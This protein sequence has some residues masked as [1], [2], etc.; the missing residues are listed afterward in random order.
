METIKLILEALY[1]GNL[2]P[3]YT[4]REELNNEAIRI[5]EC[6]ELSKDDIIELKMIL[7]IGNL[8]YNNSDRDLLPIEDG[9]YDML[10]EKYRKYNNDIYPVGATPIEFNNDNKLLEEKEM[11]KAF[12]FY[13][14]DEIEYIN[15]TMI[16]PELITRDKVLMPSDFMRPA[17]SKETGYISKRMH[18]VAHNNPELVGTFDKCKYVLTQQARDKG[19]ENDS[20][21]R[22]LER[23]FFGPLLEAGII[24]MRD[25]FTIIAELKYDGV[26]IEAEVT[27]RVLEARSRGD[28]EADIASDMTPILEGYLFPQMYGNELSKPIGMKFE[29]IVNYLNLPKLNELRGYNYINGRTAIIGIMGSSDAYKYR[30]L[31]TL[32][33]I[34]TNLKD[35]NGEPLD[36]LEELEFLNTYYTR[37]QLMRYSVFTGT[38]TQVLFLMKRFVEE[39]EYARSYLPFMYDG[40][41]FE[42][43]DKD[44]RK[45]LGRDNSID[46]YKVAVKFNPMCKQTIFRQYKYTIGQDGSITPMI[47]YDPVEFYGAIHY[48]S[49]G[50][51]YERFKKLDL[52][53]GDIIDVEY[54]NDVMPYVTK[55]SNEHNEINAKMPHNEL[56]TFPTECPCCGKPLVISPSGKSVRCTNLNCGNRAV[57]RMASTFEKLGITD[58]SEK[59]IKTVGL[60]RLVDYFEANKSVFEILGPN[61]AEALYNQLQKIKM[62]PIYDYDFFGSLG[63]TS[64]AK[65]TWKLVFSHMTVKSLVAGMEIQNQD[66][67]LA[68][69]SNI[70]GVG[71]TTANTIVNEFDFFMDDI[72]YALQNIPIQDSMGTSS[73]KQI[74]FT[75]CRDKQLVEQLVSMGCD[76]DGDAGITKSTDILI[77]PSPGYSSGRKVQ[78]AKDYGILIVPIDEFRNNMSQYL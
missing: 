9:I 55:P 49:S 47:Y 21:V 15:E 43:Y 78:K 71:P 29:A 44:I 19:V 4:Y 24:N 31:I 5:L 65:K 18:N 77:V 38:Y 2:A 26:S 64:V 57:K 20:N 37:D 7:D 46:R 51:S 73:G 56:D 40:V 35:D 54:T 48:K 66:A 50:H 11:G 41:V 59:S 62:T 75:G 60:Y 3:A 67:L 12:S 68:D 28:T 22:I 61:N 23:D 16:F 74:R 69:L 36:R 63:F 42:F 30:D 72:F 32:V 34:S 13:E 6:P 17:F 25:E 33:P 58:F 52:H 76:A 39:A 1:A 27:D 8:T 45:K 10:I 14:N 53:V 70:K